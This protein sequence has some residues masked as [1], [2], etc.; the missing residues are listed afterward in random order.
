MALQAL[1][2]SSLVLAA[3]AAPQPAPSQAQIWELAVSLSA[4]VVYRMDSMPAR[5]HKPGDE[6]LQDARRLANQLSLP[7]P[8]HAVLDAAEAD[9]LEAMGYLLKAKE[10]PTTQA[11]ERRTGTR[12]RRSSNSAC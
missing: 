11:L 5:L 6:F 12:P 7:L 4:G 2:L 1:V 8:S 10:H 9:T 3:P